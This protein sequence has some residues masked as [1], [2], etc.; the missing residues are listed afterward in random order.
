MADALIRTRKTNYAARD[1]RPPF[2]REVAI[3]L[4]VGSAPFVNVRKKTG[5]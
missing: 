3:T 1:D 5:I 4:I 2:L